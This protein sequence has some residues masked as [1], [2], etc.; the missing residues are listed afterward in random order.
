MHAAILALCIWYFRSPLTTEIVAAGDGQSAGDGA[1]EVG[2]VD[3]RQLGLTLPR[4]VSFVGQTNDAANNEVVETERQKA[5]ADA[6]VL[7]GQTKPTPIPEKTA[8]T[9]RPTANQTEQLVTQKPLQGK[10][11]NTNV[12]VGRSFGSQTPAMA[13]GVGVGSAAN[14]GAG[15]VPGG[16]DYGRLI[17]RILG[18]NYQPPA[19]TEAGET[20][21]VIVQLRISREG[22]ILSLAGGRV[23]ANYIKRRSSNGLVNNAA[24][25][26]VLAS[27]PLPPFPNGFL[28][29]AQEAVAEIW[30][31]Y[32]K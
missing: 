25:R 6:E 14:V 22:R 19:S 27:N 1:I 5:A 23:A 32:P 29:G 31:R 18:Q 7:P 28:L 17:Q 15:G 4:S 26:A 13:G 24:E 16:S 3:A 12:E 9:N 21:Y 8:K 20:Q 2:T 30:F 11:A 10:S